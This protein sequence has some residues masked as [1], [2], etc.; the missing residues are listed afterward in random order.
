MKKLFGIAMIMMMFLN[1]HSQN[2]PTI[3]SKQISQS[4]GFHNYEVN[5]T[6]TPESVPLIDSLRFEWIRF[7]SEKIQYQF[8]GHI[9]K[10]LNS[11][12]YRFDTYFLGPYNLDI[13]KNS[14]V[15]QTDNLDNLKCYVKLSTYFKNST[16][17]SET[18]FFK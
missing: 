3:I 17:K 18:F 9:T 12:E 8:T 10:T 2:A 6:I 14:V 11:A 13:Y 15:Y 1:A 5:F 4:K 7:D 16:I